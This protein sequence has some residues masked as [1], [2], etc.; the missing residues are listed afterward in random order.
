MTIVTKPNPVAVRIQP[1]K[2]FNLCT[3]TPDALGATADGHGV[4][5]AL[6]SH[7]ATRVDLCLFTEGGEES[8]FQLESRTGDI[9]HGYLPGIGPGQLY[10][11]RVHG[12]Q[13]PEQGHWF[14]PAKLLLDPYARSIQGEP[15]W[16]GPLWFYEQGHAGHQDRICLADSAPAMPKCRVVDI[17][18][19]GSMSSRPGTPW[20]DTIIYELHPR[21]YTM[22]HP[23][24]PENLRGHLS[25]LADPSVLAHLRYLGVTAVELLPIQAGFDDARLAQQGLKNYWRYNSIGF[26]APESRYVAGEG[27]E[28]VRNVVSRFHQ[29][30]I[31]VIMDVAFNHTAEGDHLGPM[32]SFRGI[33][34]VS[35]YRLNAAHRGY[36]ENDTG[37]GNTLD[38]SQPQ[39]R[40]MALDSLRFWADT[41][42]VDGFRFDLA[43]TLGRC[44]H[45]FDR[46]SPFFAALRH[47]PLLGRLK[48]IAEPWDIGQDGYQLGNFPAGFSEWNDRFRDD[49]RRFWRGDESM[50][51]N[52]ATRLLG[53]SD[54]FKD[55]DRPSRASLNFI[56]A[57]DGF[58]LQDLVSFEATRNLANLEDN[59]D[60]HD[61]NY[62]RNYGVDGPTDDAQTAALRAKQKRNL[63]ASLLLSQGTP[64]VLAG[65]EL[66]NSQDGNNNAYCQD[67]EIG[68]VNWKA[69]SLD[70]DFLDFFAWLIK[71]RKNN[72]ILRQ[73]QFLRGNNSSSASI[74]DATWLCP[75]GEEMTEDHWQ[76]GWAKC[77]GL[78]LHGG[79][80]LDLSVQHGS[81][82]SNSLL[83]VVN[84]SETDL[85]FHAPHVPGSDRWKLQI[86]TTATKGRP[87]QITYVE[88]GRTFALPAQSLLLLSADMPTA[89]PIANS[90]QEKGDLKQLAGL[91]GI[92][93]GY[94]D[95]LGNH[96]E[97]SAET[98]KAL[99]AAM[100]VKASS[101]AEIQDSL[102]DHLRHYCK[103][104][105]RP[106]HVVR[107]GEPFQVEFT[108]PADVA[109][110]SYRWSIQTEQGDAVRNEGAVG[111]L[112]SGDDRFVEDERWRTFAL[113]LPTTLPPG[114]HRL[115]LEFGDQ[116]TAETTIIAAPGRVF[117]PDDLEQPCRHWG[118]LA[119][120]YGLR[121][122][123]NTAIGDLIDLKELVSLLA[124]KGGSFVG[125]NPI[126]ALNP[127]LPHQAS[128]YSP[129][130]RLFLNELL[131]GLDTSRARRTKGEGCWPDE[132]IDYASAG[133]AKL[134]GLLRQFQNVMAGGQADL[135]P[136][137]AYRADRGKSLERFALFR[138]LFEYFFA[139]DPG[140]YWTWKHWPETY[141]HP[142]HPEVQAFAAEHR[143]RIEFFSFVQWLADQQLE[144]AQTG[145]I[146][147]GMPIGLYLDL[148]VGI[149]PHG[150]DCWADQDSFAKGA[151]LGA[152]PD[153]F[154]PN[155]QNWAL[156]PFRP[157]ELEERAYRPFID[158]IRASMRHAGAL[159]IDHVIGL[160]RSF[161][162]PEDQ[163]LGGTYVRYPIYDLLGVIALESHRHRCLVI[164]E[165]L[166]NLPY[167][168]R[169][170]LDRR[171]VMSSRVMYFERDQAGGFMRSDAFPGKA[172]V[173]AGTHDLP[174]LTGYWQGRDIDVRA[175][176]GIDPANRSDA[177]HEER[178]HDRRKL[179]T[180]LHDEGL[181]PAE[182][183]PDHPPHEMTPDL[184]A[185][186]HAFLARSPSDLMA[187]QLED[188]LG[189]LEQANLPG[190][191]DEHPNWRRRMPP[192]LADLGSDPLA[193]LIFDA[194]ANERPRRQRDP[195]NPRSG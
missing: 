4:N 63:I 193:N 73:G 50:L 35:Y 145:A 126:T 170:R 121:S 124:E 97:V 144:Q 78:L 88:S 42:G 133:P 99:L 83:I 12:P 190:T 76:A 60:G 23:Q 128:P 162:I 84:A 157:F 110:R 101:D 113:P 14:N 160:Q 82:S 167:G 10:G 184:L 27:L 112:L 57:H 36:Y 120:L 51:S 9:W 65:D 45:G 3:G 179:L 148:A 8:R 85:S 26:F 188:I 21:G 58:A 71:F 147:Q 139:K 135:L 141:Q 11:Y 146:E 194:I 182:I 130:S 173:T 191:V 94:H 122:E 117:S 13:K 92:E 96:H 127:T 66:G 132:L 195:Q 100:G 150:A 109:R 105:L 30:G 69:S 56:T 67:N 172:L 77:L 178:R 17:D 142:D 171:N 111:D 185:A 33:D 143:D 90:D 54:V 91:H 25:A 115:S 107:K 46:D 155:G 108:L 175:D 49:V 52:L 89:R 168:L 98:E 136:F 189:Q 131:V 129:S 70:S 48:L 137:Q 183:D 62:S 151:Y 116:Y 41:A 134:D 80:D 1:M 158:V 114:Y 176:L 102:A 93:P 104:I 31:E 123:R 140:H 22:Q 86:D 161:W 20:T 186:I 156:A 177:M 159:R 38:F 119:P 138:A 34:N 59:R 74:K 19:L 15:D 118:M 153:D 163:D 28:A 187:V 47:N 18:S 55:H 72:P 106:V 181:L 43:T 2:T 169:E 192:K 87:R 24:I 29:A 40:Q 75:N 149:D 180:R 164:G 68:W 125:I 39:V 166:G 81:F 95:A 64:M 154:N 6:F 103:R 37:C 165:D 61:A 32:L 174:T 44:G 53:S 7:H 79:D 152:P 5:F 16:S